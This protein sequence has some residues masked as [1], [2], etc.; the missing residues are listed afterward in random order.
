MD[1]NSLIPVTG[2][3]P[4]AWGWLKFL[5]LLTFWLHLLCMNIMLGTGTITLAGFVLKTKGY[6]N[7][8]R[9][10]R[11]KITYF[12]AFTVT[13]GVAPLL[14][15]QIL[16]GRFMYTS[17][18]L[19]AWYWLAIVGILLI[20]YYSAY[21]FSFK[22]DTLIPSRV[23]FLSITVLL[24]LLIAFLFSNNMILMLIPEKWQYYF[25][26]PGGT[27]L[28]LSE[29]T[30]W[31]RFLHFFTASI[32]VGGLFLALLFRYRMA[33]GHTGTDKHDIAVSMKWFTFGTMLHLVTGA[34]YLLSL[35][36]NIRGL[37]LGDNPFAT[38]LFCLGCAGGVLSVFLGWLKKVR[39][40]CGTVLAT[41]IIMVIIRDMVRDA[42]LKPFY[43]VSD[44]TVSPEY[45]PFFIFLGA[46]VLGLLIV[47]YMLKLAFY[48]SQEGVLK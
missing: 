32:S 18:I 19:M 4:V 46:L 22:F 8:A 29:K 30:L 33:K 47:I 13:L 43:S 15:L 23:I 6:L 9:T 38:T 34:A 28:I 24:M 27:L 36:P 21:I 1:I 26:H 20:A 35:P 5:L 7:T 48:R 44:L 39:L 40:A 16:Y 17:S 45:T 25:N 12:I 14:F 3:I 37:F 31:P 10:V 42:Y 2:T 11:G 41:M